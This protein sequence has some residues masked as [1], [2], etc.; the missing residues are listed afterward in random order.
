MAFTKIHES[1]VYARDAGADL[2]TNLHYFAKVDTDGDIVLAGD[3][4]AALGTI[5]EA[6]VENSPVTVQ[7]GGIGKVI[8]GGAVTAGNIIASD[9][10][11]KA[12]AAAVGDFVVGIALSDADAS[13][14]FSFAFVSG[15]R[16][17]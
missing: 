9:G 4:E 16:H 13:D 6:A 12:V 2:S 10:D 14:I 7:F 17:A 8:A 3:G 11:G 5:I 15:R 1:L